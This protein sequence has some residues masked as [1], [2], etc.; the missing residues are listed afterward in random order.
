MLSGVLSVIRK[1]FK[2]NLS[3]F[4]FQFSL[5]ALSLFLG[6]TLLNDLR[7][8]INEVFCFLQA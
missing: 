8:A 2:G 3:A 5:D 1:L 4:S 6:C 7:S